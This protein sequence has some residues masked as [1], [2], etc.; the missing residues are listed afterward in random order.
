LTDL[1]YSL[2]R[3]TT[4]IPIEFDPLAQ[5][6]HRAF[7]AA[8]AQ[9][10]SYFR[11]YCWAVAGGGF[12]NDLLS[13]PPAW[14]RERRARPPAAVAWRGGA[15]RRSPSW[16]DAGSR[17]QQAMLNVRVS[18]LDAMLAHLRAKGACG[19]PPDRAFGAQTRAR[20]VADRA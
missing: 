12:N 2:S 20:I 3:V 4:T 11:P 13:R 7:T 16:Q 1:S 6:R 17:S 8:A 15:A 18:D 14:R 10:L 5:D 19:S 9:G